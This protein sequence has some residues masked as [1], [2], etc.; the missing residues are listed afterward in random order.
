[1][2]NK[3]RK[4]QQTVIGTALAESRAN[5]ERMDALAQQDAADQ[6]VAI[7]STET[8]T[9]ALQQMSAEISQSPTP[10]GVE[11]ETVEVAD[12]DLALK[13]PFS[14]EAEARKTPYLNAGPRKWDLMEVTLPSVEECKALLA[15]VEGGQTNEF[16]WEVNHTHAVAL[17][18]RKI[19]M[20]AGKAGAM[21]PGQGRV[22]LTEENAALKAAKAEADKQ[23]ADLMAQLAKMQG[24]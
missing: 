7:A 24:K 17:S 16:V 22:K 12:Q 11:L 18:A 3:N 23:I 10:I 19:G 2:S 6:A 5:A 1:M 4:S 21:R 15:R 8:V 14:T 20:S 9:A 13:G